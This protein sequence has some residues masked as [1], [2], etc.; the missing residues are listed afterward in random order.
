MARIRD[1]DVAA[2]RDVADIRDV[3]GEY[4]TLKSA[5]GGSYK[6]LC[7]FHDERTP[8]FHV[9]P[10][11]GLYHCFSC[12]EGGDLIG[13]LRKLE[14]LTFTEAVEKIAG[15]YGV[16]LRYD[17][18]SSRAA[19]SAGQRPR[20]VAAHKVASE[21]YAA[22][23]GEPGAQKA[24]EFLLGRGFGEDSWPTFAVGYAPQG[25]DA[26]TA[27]LK[28]AGFTEQEMLAGGLVSQGQRGVYDRFRGRVVWPIR[29]TSGDV[30]GFGARKLYDDDEG[31]KYLNTPETPIYKKSQVLYGLDLAR[32]DIARQQKAV[33]VE[34]YTDVMACV[35]AGVTTAVATCGTAFGSEH[36]KILRRILL[37]TPDA[38]AEV[39][40][41]F[42]GDSAGQKA[43]MKAFEH[44]QQFAAKTFVAVADDGMDPCDLRLTQ[45]DTAVQA[46]VA[47]RVPMF[48]FVIKS[49][50]KQH[51][52]D[53]AE[54]RVTA[55]RAAAPVVAT[56]KDTT[57]RP[58]YT[59]SL[60]GWLGM[61]ESTVAREVKDASKRRPAAPPIAPRRDPANPV[62]ASTTGHAQSS[63]NAAAR[64]DDGA[65][66]GDGASGDASAADIATDYGRP[67]PQDRSVPVQRDV[68]GCVLQAP[69]KVGEWY[70][71]VEPT[72]Y[73]W[74]GFAAVH[75]AIVAAGRP[76][77][78]EAQG[79]G[80]SVWV[81]S[82]LDA[83]IDDTVRSYVRQLIARPLPVDQVD[84]RYATSLVARLLELDTLR[85]TQQ[86]QGKLSRMQGSD[87]P[88]V[89]EQ[90]DEVMRQLSG[91]ES[92]RR[93]LR[94]I[95]QGEP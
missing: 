86:L 11:K 42:D 9:T 93:E 64:D 32:R 36:V 18:T 54:G 81:Q 1:E 13:F 75:E 82:V 49:L 19:A 41:T 15:R 31:P 2:V 70:D 8:S 40:F 69:T 30:V 38:A 80:E 26:L 65:T 39:I 89:A 44:D 28:A 48:V 37:D 22:Q 6:G 83:C 72:A 55:L 59:R 25:W 73:T 58:E 95:V 45:G 94:S 35:L 61:D 63:L 77:Q 7:P 29:D 50:L 78:M 79:I 62:G 23:L 24:R 57:L 87:E 88:D 92:Y 53:T 20:L 90:S 12:Q 84:P 74:I 76:A 67:D 71:S 16:E 56:I 34:G 85:Q 46:L 47:S 17:E 14:G 60:A 10:S 21:F 51:D 68:L 91:L 66:S 3:V 5:G 27:R 43:A 33:I 4:V 52:L